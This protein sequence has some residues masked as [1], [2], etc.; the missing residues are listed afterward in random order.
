MTVALVFV[1]FGEALGRRPA[2]RRARRPRRGRD[3]EPAGAR[4]HL[5]IRVSGGSCPGPLPPRSSPRS[6]SP[7]CPLPPTPRRC[8]ADQ[9]GPTVSMITDATGIPTRVRI[10]W[11][12]RCKKPGFR[13]LDL[14]FF[15]PPFDAVTADAITDA[16][17][18]RVRFRGG[19]RGRIT[20]TLQGTRSGN[21][22]SGT[23]RIKRGLQQARQGDARVPL[24]RVQLVGPVRALAI[25]LAALMLVPAAAEAT[26]YRGKTSQGRAASIRT[27]ADGDRQPRAD[28][29][30]RALRPEQALRGGDGVPA[31]VRHGD[32]RRAAGR[33]D[34]PAPGLGRSSGGSR[35]P[36]RR[37]AMPRR[38][39]WAGTLVGQRCRS[40]GAGA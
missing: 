18:Y 10:A 29:L 2:A 27:G 5:T 35:S 12:A 38:N 32:R 11:R 39:R 4:R 31:A 36:S 40:R 26:T 9:P 8:A 30:A 13:S 19:L 16:G 23:L 1:T 33:R 3:R 24:G 21:R 20:G 14:T 34:L 6:C 37:S 22:W 7:P 25:A 15:S 17:T 28:Q